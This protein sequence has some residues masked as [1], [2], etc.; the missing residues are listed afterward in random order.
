MTFEKN[1]TKQNKRK[2]KHDFVST[3]V[4]IAGHYIR[5]LRNQLTLFNQLTVYSC[6]HNTIIPINNSIALPFDINDEPR[7]TDNLLI[8]SVETLGPQ[9]SNFDSLY[10]GK[11]AFIK[12]IN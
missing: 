6:F 2:N 4:L 10:G 11:L 12:L 9:T 7:T 5:F 1:K 8:N 3:V